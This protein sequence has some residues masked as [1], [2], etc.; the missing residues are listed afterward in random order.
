MLDNGDWAGIAGAVSAVVGAVS[1]WLR[2]YF[3][4]RREARAHELELAKLKGGA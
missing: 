2:M 1:M 4:D 3:T